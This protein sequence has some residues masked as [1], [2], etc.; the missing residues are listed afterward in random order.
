MTI[1]RAHAS[2]DGRKALVVGIANEQS[3]AW[4]CA[5]WLRALGADI[6]VTYLN[7]KAKR[8]VEPLANELEAPLLLPL[9]ARTPGQFEAVFDV[10]GV[11]PVV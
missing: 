6:A 8:Y 11:G 4:G 9:D 10:P 1:P 3:I 5:K 2:L 7:D